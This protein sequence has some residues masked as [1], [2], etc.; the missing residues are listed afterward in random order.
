MHPPDLCGLESVAGARHD[1]THKPDRAYVHDVIAWL[2][3]WLGTE[4]SIFVKVSNRLI[5]LIV[6]NGIGLL[7][8]GDCV[9]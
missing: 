7:E 1:Q 4:R 2:R 9:L 8:Y 6:I 3:G 5:R